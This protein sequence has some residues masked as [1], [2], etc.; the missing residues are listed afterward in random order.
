MFLVYVQLLG[1]QRHRE[2]AAALLVLL[3]TL[4]YLFKK[5]NSKYTTILVLWDPINRM[6]EN[7][8]L[9][10]LIFG[11]NIRGKKNPRTTQVC[12]FS[13]SAFHINF[14]YFNWKIF[15]MMVLTFMV[16]CHF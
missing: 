9:G 7:I 15:S 1:F 2:P 4:F 3:E 8:S 12:L 10:L 13:I 11:A 14:R 6:K 5:Y 16:T